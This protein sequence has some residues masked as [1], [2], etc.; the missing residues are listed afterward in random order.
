MGY[1]QLSKTEKL[2]FHISKLDNHSKKINNIIYAQASTVCIR[3]IKQAAAH[4]SQN[5]N[6]HLF[7]SGNSPDDFYGYGNQFYSTITEVHEKFRLNW[8]RKMKKIIN[9]TKSELVHVHNE[10][11]LMPMKIM[12]WDLGIPVIYDQHDFLSG[13]KKLSSKLLN[14]EK[15][16]NE[17]NDG[18]IF[19]TDNYKDLVAKKYIIN[20]L[21][22]SFPNFGSM[23]MVLNKEQMMPKLS[24]L[25]K[26]IHLVYVGA[27]D[28]ERPNITRYLI[29]QMKELSDQGFII[30]IYPSIDDNYD[31]YKTLN[32]VN[33]MKKQNP[34][35][36]IRTLSQYDC[37]L[38]LVNPNCTNMPEELKFGFWNKAFDYL[39]AGIPQITLEIFSVI[40]NFIKKN[41]FGITVSSLNELNKNH[42]DLSGHL[43][44]LHSN[45]LEKNRIYT[46]ENQINKMHN[47]Y[48]DVIKNYHTK[49]IKTLSQ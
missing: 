6:V 15:Y 13:K 41:N 34:K 49:K 44:T 16:C 17:K 31:K 38:T 42:D 18:G 10:P 9:K 19:I 35:E 1:N 30:D 20:N 48:N 7:Y 24:K 14:H 45:I 2:N 32:N 33:V 36:L 29:P 43:N 22:I 46:Y 47:F 40:S 37:G 26:K 28:Q 5:L 8:K 27:L 23:D 4:Q 25:S 3:N 11:D 39:M 21:N 12:K